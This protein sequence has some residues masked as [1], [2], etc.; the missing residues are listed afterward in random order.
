[1]VDD[2]GGRSG[3]RLFLYGGVVDRHFAGSIRPFL[4]AAGG[5][6]RLADRYTC[7]LGVARAKVL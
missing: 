1:M 2:G 7:G 6:H 5:A 3:G 4:A